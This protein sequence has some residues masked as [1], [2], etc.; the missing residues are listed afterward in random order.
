MILP[1][2]ILWIVLTGPG[3][4]KLVPRGVL[5]SQKPLLVFDAADV[6]QEFL[7]PIARD[8]VMRVRRAVDA[9]GNHF[10]WDLSATDRRLNK[11]ANFFYHCLC[12]HGPRPHDLY[13]WHFVENYFPAERILPVYGYPYEVTVRCVD[14]EVNGRKYTE[15][16]FTRGTVE[17]WVRRLKVSNPK[18]LTLK[19]MRR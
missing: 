1:S 13:A 15:A 14:C 17:I 16:R 4:Q 7:V 8:V 5:V 10:G 3:D 19:D 18:Q 9:H 6:R 11:E 2:L 12:G